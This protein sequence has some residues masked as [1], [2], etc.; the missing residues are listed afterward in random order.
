MCKQTVPLISLNTVF[1]CFYSTDFQCHSDQSSLQ[2][3]AVDFPRSARGLNVGDLYF[4]WTSTA[5]DVFVVGSA[6]RWPHKA[7]RPC[8]Q[9][10]LSILSRF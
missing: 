4:L 6:V 10:I 2:Q 7:R 8:F 5:K 9:S 1:Y 3:Q